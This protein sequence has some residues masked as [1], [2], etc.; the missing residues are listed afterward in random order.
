MKTV[1][2]SLKQ[3]GF[4]TAS[5][6]GIFDNKTSAAVMKFQKSKKLKAD[7]IIGRRT[8]AALK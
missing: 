3:Q 2:N 7:G 6:N 4:Y 1:Q 5:V 8:L